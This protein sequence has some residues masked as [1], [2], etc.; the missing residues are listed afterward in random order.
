MPLTRRALFRGPRPEP[1]LSAL[2]TMIAARGHEESLAVGAAP[3]PP[4]ADAI[5]ISGNENPLGPGPRALEAVIAALE[6]SG[7][8]PLNS[9]PG[10]TDLTAAIAERFDADP[11][12]I[13]VG[14]GSSE[15]LRNAVRVFAGGGRHVVTADPSYGSPVTESTKLGYT[16][17]QVPVDSELRLD[18]DGMTSRARGAGFVYL[19]NPNNPTATI[20]PP[21]A[22]ENFIVAIRRAAPEALIL[23]DEAYHDYVTD[24]GHR[25]MIPL[26]LSEPNVVVARTFSKAYGMAGLRLGFGI[27]HRDA[28]E[29]LRRYK[30]SANANVLAIAAGVASLRDPGHIERERERNRE[31]R[32]FTRVFFDKAGYRSTESQTNFLFVELRRPAK[33]FRD[34]CGKRNVVVG[35]DFPPM[36]KIHCRISIGTMEEMRRACDV[37]AEV[38]DVAATD[39]AGGVQ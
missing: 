16:C 32:T 10:G 12:Q 34:A 39:A 28:V 6:Q 29:T 24:P 26:A 23:V 9:H 20:H 4:N 17:L 30:L 22:L 1:T 7:R 36:E 37:F 21:A 19:C 33:G 8:Y 18:L 2:A 15:I 11:E 5:R 27:G 3:A 35:R 13:V 31:A 38:L 25:S 14:A